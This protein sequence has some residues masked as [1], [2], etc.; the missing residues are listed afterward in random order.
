MLK[1][2]SLSDLDRVSDVGFYLC[3][4]STDMRKGFDALAE[5]ARQVHRK[6]VFSGSLFIFISRRKDRM[7]ILYWDK[8]G[9]ALWYKRLEEGTFR[10]PKYCDHGVG[11]KASELAM[12]LDG[13]DLR[14]LK[15][16]K[17]FTSCT[18]AAAVP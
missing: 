12:L 3:T 11:I 6:D 1:P 2:P 17:R 5:L 14:S 18:P 7:K 16:S 15:R 4:Q 8:D 13:V 9:L 10:L